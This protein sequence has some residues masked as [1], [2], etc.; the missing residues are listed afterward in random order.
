[1]SKTRRITCFS[2]FYSQIDSILPR[3]LFAAAAADWFWG[4]SVS[5][6]INISNSTV[7]KL[8]GQGSFQPVAMVNHLIS[9]PLI[10]LFR[11]LCTRSIQGNFDTQFIGQSLDTG[12]E[13]KN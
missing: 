8:K 10:R 6:V 9:V 5:V 3:G 1:M 12:S 4:V 13:T 7:E 2:A 11:S